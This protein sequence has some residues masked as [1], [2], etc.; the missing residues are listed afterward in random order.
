VLRIPV[1]GFLLA[2][3]GAVTPGPLLALVMGQVLAQGLPAA[4]WIL[5]GHALLEAL[6]VGLLAAG[7]AAWLASA[8]LR[9][10]ISICGGAVL[11]WMGQDMLRHAA[12]LS[13]RGVPAHALSGP[14]LLLA[15]AGVSLA[16]PY[17]SGWWATV[18]SSQVAALG[19]RGVRA[20]ILLWLGHEGGDFVWY[21]LVAVL[22]ATGRGWLTD[23]IYQD[24]V[25]LCGAALVGLGVWFLTLGSAFAARRRSAQP[26]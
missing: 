20:Y 6:L 2:L 17:F 14:A 5:S 26:Q 8:R 11:I 13:W 21:L 16:N 1:L 4:L 12:R 15:G 9:G 18:G 25:A 19:L 7:A 3:T 23:R 10:P 24:L 22:L